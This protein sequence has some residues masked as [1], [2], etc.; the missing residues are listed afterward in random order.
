MLFSPFVNVINRNWNIVSFSVSSPS[1]FP[2]LSGYGGKGVTGPSPSHYVS[3]KDTLSVFLVSL[4][5]RNLS[6]DRKISA[7][8]SW[9]GL[10]RLRLGV[11]LLNLVGI[12][13]LL[14]FR[15]VNV[16]LKDVWHGDCRLFRD[17]FELS[18]WS[19]ISDVEDPLRMTTWPG[20]LSLDP[21]VHWMTL[22]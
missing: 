2:E 6:H 19:G 22:C 18:V 8:F 9:P 1:F 11:S 10:S 14:V 3:T 13:L 4:T 21:S 7:F 15:V 17:L 20:C 5:L 12:D 16:E